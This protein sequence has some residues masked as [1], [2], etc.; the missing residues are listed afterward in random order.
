VSN[1]VFPSLPGLKWNQ[2]KTPVFST[3]IQIAASGRESR[4]PLYVYPLYEFDLSYEILRDDTAHNELKSLASFY[5]RMGGADDDF[6]YID[7]S[8]NYTL[9]SLIGVGDGNNN[10]FQM[11]RSYGGFIEPRYDIQS[12]NNQIPIVISVNGNTQANNSYSINYL[13]SGILTFNT[14]PI[15]VIT[16]NFSYYYRVR[17]LEYCVGGSAFSQFMKNLWE[18]KSVSF[19]TVR[20]EGNAYLPDAALSPPNAIWINMLM[21]KQ[22]SNLYQGASA[23]DPN[24]SGWN[25]TQLGYW[26]LNTSDPHYK[27]WNGNEILILG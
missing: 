12:S 20:Q 7:P 5:L 17:F 21:N 9:N 2:G 15:G 18:A 13:R 27:W 23:N 25:N 26:W 3:L 8:D 4:T 6:L 22:T 19:S 10:S 11:V 24:T 1:E 16:A 14:N